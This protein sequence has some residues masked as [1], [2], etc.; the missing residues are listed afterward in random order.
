MVKYK[1]FGSGGQSVGSFSFSSQASQHS[2]KTTR[3]AK[4]NK[5]H[6]RNERS[7]SITRRESEEDDCR[8]EDG[9]R[10][11]PR[12]LPNDSTEEEDIKEG[13]AESLYDM[14]SYNGITD[15]HSTSVCASYSYSAGETDS[16]AGYSDSQQ[17]THD[18]RRSK[19]SYMGYVPM[20]P[21]T[22][23]AMAAKEMR[24]HSNTHRH[25]NSNSN[26][27]T[28]K[29]DSAH[30]ATTTTG[31]TFPSIQV[32]DTST[33]RRR[34]RDYDDESQPEQEHRQSASIATDNVSSHGVADNITEYIT[35]G[36]QRILDEQKKSKKQYGQGHKDSATEISSSVADQNSRVED[37]TL[38]T[39]VASSVKPNSCTG[40]PAMKV[41]NQGRLSQ[42]HKH[43]YHINT[44]QPFQ[45]L[46]PV[47]ASPPQTPARV[48]AGSSTPG[49]GDAWPES[50][51]ILSPLTAGVSAYGMVPPALN[52]PPA[53]KQ[54]HW[55]PPN[56]GF[57][58]QQLGY[59]QQQ[60]AQYPYGPGGYS[61][62]YPSNQQQQQQQSSKSS[63]FPRNPVLAQQ[64]QAFHQYHS[65]QQPPPMTPPSTSR[66][67]QQ[68]QKS[69]PT[70]TPIVRQNV[71]TK[72]SKSNGGVS[73]NES[74][75]K[76]ISSTDEDQPVLIC[77]TEGPRLMD[78]VKFVTPTP[79][80][81]GGSNNGSSSLSSHSM[82]YGASYS[83]GALGAGCGQHPAG[84]KCQS[85]LAEVINTCGA[86]VSHG[87]H[88]DN[89]KS[90]SK[91]KRAKFG[92]VA[93]KSIAG[94]TPNEQ[95]REE[96]GG[97]GISGIGSFDAFAENAKKILHAGNNMMSTL[98]KDFQNLTQSA[99]YHNV[100]APFQKYA[101]MTSPRRSEKTNVVSRTA[102]SDDPH[103][104][105]EVK[106]KK[107]PLSPIS[108]QRDHFR[109]LRRMR[110]RDADA[111]IQKSREGNL[112]VSPKRTDK[113][114]KEPEESSENLNRKYARNLHARIHGNKIQIAIR[115]ENAR[116]PEETGKDFAENKDDG[117]HC[118][119][120]TPL[121]QEESED[122]RESSA[123]SDPL[124]ESESQTNSLGDVQ[125]E[126]VA[127]DVVTSTS[128]GMSESLVG[129]DV[130]E[131]EQQ[132]DSMMNSS[133][134]DEEHQEHAE[135]DGH[136]LLDSF[137]HEF[138]HTQLDVIEEESED[139]DTT[140]HPASIKNLNSKDFSVDAPMDEQ[141]TH[142]SQSD[143]MFD[144]LAGIKTGGFRTS[145]KSMIGIIRIL[146]VAMLVF[147]CGTVICMREHIMDQIRNIEGGPEVLAKTGEFMSHLKASGVSLVTT[148]KD[149]I[150]LHQ[151]E[152]RT[153]VLMDTASE[154]LSGFKLHQGPA[155]KD[156]MQLF[157]QLIDDAFGDD[158]ALQI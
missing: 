99:A 23:A 57:H 108:A 64:L 116:E 7:P 109:K 33:S 58:Q 132:L 88:V 12:I 107:A 73:S 72:I 146:F 140:V 135:G 9:S 85:Y 35:V 102:V 3:T 54:Q 123:K 147:Q 121:S 21:N 25:R 26:N 119:W 38:G 100:F 83:G 120:G 138:A 90:S 152:S 117:S 145:I 133:L 82:A 137:D 67:P 18:S 29:N 134:S 94:L 79:R 103:E 130:G 92:K 52:H 151:I 14:V 8:D 81:S 71:E 66:R 5:S 98:P 65:D 101:P 56:P 115:T 77:G 36:Q 53:M 32:D 63:F 10:F 112:A 106:E 6:R 11:D 74:N 68:P 158:D 111:A 154:F 141:A 43:S 105:E 22:A 131:E 155:E 113:E 78:N 126:K 48:G 49:H 31:S 114:K 129:S 20:S 1:N 59:H 24:D 62:Q 2:T 96:E 124:P 86:I 40:H 37:G 157:H 76:T 60:P 45:P 55:N 13:E 80:R 93:A 42:Q 127:L 142:I 150:N 153:M 30:E 89:R 136:L 46:S 149:I 156:E 143:S 34:T 41:A 27:D 91:Q 118:S 17:Q 44:N 110:N 87:Y 128:S 47:A 39:S 104:V 19:L 4:S 95:K 139:E 125:D 84:V 69:H 97:N 122:N 144:E 75:E 16:S 50:M 15:E 70:K 51:S 148:A 28:N 61:Q